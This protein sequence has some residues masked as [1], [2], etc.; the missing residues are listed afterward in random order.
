MSLVNLKKYKETLT[1]LSQKYATTEDAI[2][3]IFCFGLTK[4]IHNILLRKQSVEVV[5]LV[6]QHSQSKSVINIAAFLSNLGHKIH[7]FFEEGVDLSSAKLWPFSSH[8]LKSV[9]LLESYLDRIK[10]EYVFIDGLME[11]GVE[12][13]ISDHSYELIK[14]INECRKDTFSLDVPSG[15]HADT[16]EVSSTAIKA[17]YTLALGPAKLGLFINPG[18][19][20]SGKLINTNG[21]LSEEIE[22]KSDYRLVNKELIEMSIRNRD[23]LAEK[24]HYGHCLI[25]GGSHGRIGSVEMAARGAL[26]SGTG[27]VTAATWQPQ[28]EQL[29]SQLIPEIRSGYI[30]IDEAK[31]D[32]V[33]DTMSVYDSLVV[34]PGLGLS[35]RSRRVVLRLLSAF[36]GPVILDADAINIIKYDK[37]Q[38]YFLNRK[39]PTVLTPDKREFSQMLGVTPEQLE[40][41]TVKYLRMA[42][43]RFKSFVMLK[44]ACTYLA[45]PSGEIYFHYLPNSGMATS[46]SGDVLS[47]VLAGIMAQDSELSSRDI[48]SDR[49]LSVDTSLALGLYLHSQAGLRAKSQFGE[50]GM[51]ATDIISSLP[52]TFLE[53][54]NK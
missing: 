34:G 42:V 29:C 43:D 26:R 40:K 6:G 15:L 41:N 9:R 13:P 39:H 10:G 52:S 48:L 46:G 2:E 27:L 44:G 20:F 18:P 36:N 54:Y 30:P 11:S 28:Y 5:V 37:D 53:L 17:S 23:R 51:S 49:L 50:R 35:A 38:D 1:L 12:L 24:G 31:W 21:I 4:K 19:K 7:L 22:V 3:N 16:G 32:K 47:G 45:S 25:L 8:Q 33:I 14:L